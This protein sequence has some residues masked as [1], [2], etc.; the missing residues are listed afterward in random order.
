MSNVGG[1]RG[2][3]R[4]A[5]AAQ[6]SAARNRAED[7]ASRVS[8]ATRTT[9]LV[10]ADRP[11]C[12]PSSSAALRSS[13]CASSSWDAA[14]Q[15]AGLPTRPRV[16][17]PACPWPC[18]VRPSSFCAFF[19]RATKCLANAPSQPLSHAVSLRALSVQSCPSIPPYVSVVCHCGRCVHAAEVHIRCAVSLLRLKRHTRKKTSS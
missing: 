18:P 12:D 16:Q 11:G 13:R 14:P 10:R 17:A 3:L 9:A 7:A 6:R 15:R 5:R 1:T 4:P 8:V 2:A 19:E